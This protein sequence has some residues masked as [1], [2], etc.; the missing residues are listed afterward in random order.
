[1]AVSKVMKF[2]EALKKLEGI[3]AKMEAGDLS[4]EDALKHFE[5]GIGLVKFCEVKLGEAEGKV[6]KLVKA[7]E[8]EQPAEKDDHGDRDFEAEEE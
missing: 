5:D 3:V 8:R 6:E 7:L 2:E 4:L 1:M